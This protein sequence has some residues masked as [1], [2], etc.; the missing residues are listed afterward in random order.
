MLRGDLSAD[1]LPPHFKRK[2]SVFK[3]M[4]SNRWLSLAA[5]AASVQFLSAADIVGKVSLKGNPPPE[6]EYAVSD[7]YCG[8][9]TKG[10]AMKGRVF[11]TS[12][13][14]LGDVI[15]YLK[16][17]PAGAPAADAAGPVLDQK[18]CIYEPYIL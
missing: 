2:R 13:G 11:R 18:N 12:G 17:A 15:V 8:P 7:G 10:T 6:K 4:K 3:N 16:N 5:L 1:R 9:G 14:G